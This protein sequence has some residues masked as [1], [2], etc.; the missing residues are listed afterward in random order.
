GANVTRITVSPK[1]VTLRAPTTSTFT[2][3][4]FDANGNAV[5]NVPITWSSS[6]PTVATIDAS[7]GVLA[8]AGKRGTTTV[9]ARSPTGITDNGVATI[10]LPATGMILVSGGGQSGRAGATLSLPGVVRVV[11]GDGVGVAGVTV[12]F[13]APVGGSVGSPSVTTDATGQ[14]STTL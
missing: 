4:A 3:A 10:T 14:A 2:A 13:A 7:T 9:T 11:A 1:T 12:T 8:T 6:D 5:A